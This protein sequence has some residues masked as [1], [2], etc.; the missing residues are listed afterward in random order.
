MLSSRRQ[1][2]D[3]DP[4]LVF[5]TTIWTANVIKCSSSYCKNEVTL[6]ESISFTTD[7]DRMF[8]QAQYLCMN[9]SLPSRH[10]ACYN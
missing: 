5:T 6:N 8:D 4:N 7:W 3:L 1:K 2:S 9:V 10:G